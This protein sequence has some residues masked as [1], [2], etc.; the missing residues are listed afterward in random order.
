VTSQPP[1][2][3]ARIIETGERLFAEHGLEGVSLRQI[4]AAAGNANNSAVR[5]HFG[6]K[7]ALL[8]AIFEHRLP[9][10]IDRRRSLIAEGAPGLRGSVTC[11]VRALL[12]EGERDDSDYASFAAMLLRYGRRDVFQQAPADL[13]R[14]AESFTDQQREFL[15]HLA[16]PLRRLRV[17]QA[18]NI[19]IYAAADRQR[20]RREGRPV[21]PF[22]VELTNLVD[23]IIGFLTAPM[24]PEARA[25]AGVFEADSALAPLPL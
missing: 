7:D 16:D 25:A 5:Y 20:A 15:G 1:T 4:A 6:S 8:Q 13:L 9:R 12:E 3:R 10:L 2:S 23:G 24:S 22:G 17:F 14:D 19:T 18:S 21:P 11:Q